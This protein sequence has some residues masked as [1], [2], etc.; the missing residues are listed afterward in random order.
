M[1]NPSLLRM[2]RFADTVPEMINLQREMKSTDSF[3][4]SGRVPH[5]IIRQLTSG[6]KMTVS[7]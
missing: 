3:P 5:W 1:F 2:K 6:K 4:M 7:L